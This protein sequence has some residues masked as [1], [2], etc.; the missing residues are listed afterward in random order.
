MTTEEKAKELKANDVCCVWNGGCPNVYH[1]A[2]EMAKWK[3]EQFAEEKKELID[4]AVKW[5]E[6]NELFR[7]YPQL[8]GTY[9]FMNVGIIEDFK[10]AIE[11]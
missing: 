6:K 3:D 5:F 1:A 4:K 2:M 7:A 8:N 11:E 10:K 9:H